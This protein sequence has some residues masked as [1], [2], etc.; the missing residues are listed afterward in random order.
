MVWEAG[1]LGKWSRTNLKKMPLKIFFL[2]INTTF[3]ANIM[4]QTSVGSPSH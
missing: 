2:I 3:L 4:A 1:L